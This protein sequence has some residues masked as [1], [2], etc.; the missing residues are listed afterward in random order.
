MSTIPREPAILLQGLTWQNYVDLRDAPENDHVRMTF[1]RG[2]LEL[3][4]P[5]GLRRRVRMLIGRCVKVWAEEKRVPIQSGGSTT[6]RREDLQ[7][8]LEP[9]NCYWIQHESA[10]RA[11]D[12]IDLT[13][14]P[15]PD[16]AV[17][18]DVTSRSSRKERSR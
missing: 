14:D 1:D 7:R 6:F 13:I 12:E 8:G 16:L 18:V 11:R 2:S 17:E 3:M 15:P 10:V 9:D 4:S 5:I